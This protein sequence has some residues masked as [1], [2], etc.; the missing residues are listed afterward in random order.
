MKNFILFI[1]FFKFS[2]GFAQV[3]QKANQATKNLYSRLKE[4][5]KNYKNNQNILIGHQDAFVAGQGWRLDNSWY[6][7][8]LNSDMYKVSGVHPA[9]FG[10]DLISINSSNEDMYVA[11]INEIHSRNGV[12][13]LSWHMPTVVEDGKGDNSYRDTTTKVVSH[14]LPNGHSHEKFKTLLMRLVKFFN[15]VSDVPIIFRP[16]HEHNGSW[17]WWGKDH[18]T[19]DEYIKLWRFTF[20]FFKEN[21]IHNLLYAYSPSQV[22]DDYYHRYPGDGYVDILG[23]DMYFNNYWQDILDFGPLPREE[24]SRDIYWLMLEATRK[25][26]LAAITEFGQESVKYENFWSKY[27]EGPLLLK[28]INT[29]IE[30]NYADRGISYVLLWRNDHKDLKHYFG[31][32]LGNPNSQNFKDVMLK[33]NSI[34][35]GL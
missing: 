17:F 31:P 5:A 4:I 30:K 8:D 15:R 11:I 23:T 24:W 22:K 2:L 7:T 18:S 10:I 27:L 16:Y 33:S 20:E 32:V 13:T 12:V 21:G 26:K 6:G 19:T 25:D 1:V 9:V 14:I 35:S 29:V 28:S 34:F 3:D